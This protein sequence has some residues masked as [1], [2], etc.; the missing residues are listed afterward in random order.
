MISTSDCIIVGD[1]MVGKSS[2]YT[3]GIDRYTNQKADK[4]TLNIYPLNRPTYWILCLPTP[5]KNGNQDLSAI[6]EWLSY[7]QVKIPS[8]KIIIRSTILPG[9]TD[10]LSEKYKPLIIVHIPEFL[11]ENTAIEDEKNPE[12]I[13]IGCK[14]I[15]FKKELQNFF[16]ARLVLPEE[17]FILTDPTTAEMIK[18]SMNSYFALKVIYG[19]QIWD[20]AKE[21]GADYSKVKKA[22]ETHKWGSKNGWDV[23]HGGYRGFGGHCLVKDLAAFTSKF[24]LPLLDK[25]REIN[26][27]LVSTTI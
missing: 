26:K 24:K 10:K 1:G 18:Y 9:T 5:T 20:V 17:K 4:Y 15:I 21:V 3:L 2:R 23:W 16:M 11:S 8:A 19:N 12:F 27:K 7:L 13:V 25:V 14:D 6:E 22:L